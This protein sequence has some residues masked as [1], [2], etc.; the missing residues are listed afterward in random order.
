[1]DYEHVLIRYDVEDAEGNVIAIILKV[2][3]A[4]GQENSVNHSQ[5]E[6]L[7][8]YRQNFVIRLAD[9]GVEAEAGEQITSQKDGSVMVK[10]YETAI[11]EAEI[12]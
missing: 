3:A 1:M 9:D 12:T 4:G 8:V 2:L 10:E 5:D 7:H 11:G 6:F